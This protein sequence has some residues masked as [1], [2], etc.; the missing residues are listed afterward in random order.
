MKR[1][2]YKYSFCSIKT[3]APPSSISY[4]AAS[5]DIV[6]CHLASIA[7]VNVAAS[8]TA[9]LIWVLEVVVCPVKVGKPTLKHSPTM[10]YVRLHRGFTQSTTITLNKGPAATACMFAISV[11]SPS[12]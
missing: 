3:Y 1:L 8:T 2:Q 4:C 9:S 12:V 7:E 5:A 10:K 11:A 6:H